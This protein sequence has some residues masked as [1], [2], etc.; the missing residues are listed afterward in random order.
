MEKEMLM[1]IKENATVIVGALG[2]FF[3]IICFLLTI[4]Y[5]LFIKYDNERNSRSEERFKEGEK[6]FEKIES[7]QEKIFSKIEAGQEKDRLERE[8][9]KNKISNVSDR[10]IEL[11]TDHNSNHGGN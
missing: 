7:G 3:S 6:R 11:Q 5:K 4:I 10:L 9:I 8:Q 1:F 2:C